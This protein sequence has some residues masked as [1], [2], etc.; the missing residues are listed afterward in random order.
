MEEKVFLSKLQA[1]AKQQ[2]MLTNSS[3]LPEWS[4][5]FA[6]IVGMHYWQFLLFLSCIVAMVLSVAFFPFIYAEVVGR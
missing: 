4:K 6:S 1:K 3:P 5:P 2:A